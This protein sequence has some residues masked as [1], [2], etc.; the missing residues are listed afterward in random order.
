MS[1]ALGGL[2]AGLSALWESKPDVP[3]F[4]WVD[5]VQQQLDT[6]AGNL[7]VLTDAEKL[8]SGV[9]EFMRG[10]RAKT[11]AG[12]PG[13]GDIEQE[14]AANLK[15]WLRGELPSDVTS[16]VERGA[17]ARAY[18]GGYGGA[19]MGRNLTSRDL[20]LTSLDLMTRA[21]PMGE[22]FAQSEYNL[23]KIPEFNPSSMFIDPMSAARFNAQQY[24]QQWNR[25]WL[26]SRISAQPEPWQ[27]SLMNS[28]NSLGS[29]ADVVGG[30]YLGG[31]LGGMGQGQQQPPPPPPPGTDTGFGGFTTGGYNVYTPPNVGYDFTVPG[32]GSSM[33]G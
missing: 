9:N 21:V 4:K 23:R 11:L 13:L 7:G 5:L 6:T 18:A 32:L 3:S 25:D 27:Q 10:E 14:T 26:A 19:G 2:E 1:F 15:S 8:G 24:G 31:M 12:I 30:S 28:V 16:A 20:G 22:Q 33:Y 17:N 29:M